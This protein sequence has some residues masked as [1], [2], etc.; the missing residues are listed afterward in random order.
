MP[1]SDRTA[2]GTIRSLAFAAPSPVVSTN[3]PP[4]QNIRADRLPS[5]P[6]RHVNGTATMRVLP[7]QGRMDVCKLMCKI[8]AR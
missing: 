1:Q 2:F 5:I 7:S 4:R 8:L 3:D 6:P